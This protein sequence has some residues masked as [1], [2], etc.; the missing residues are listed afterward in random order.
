M[1]CSTGHKLYES[2]LLHA[3]TQWCTATAY[4]NDYHAARSVYITPLIAH[5]FS[6]GLHNSIVESSVGGKDMLLDMTSFGLAFKDTPAL[7]SFGQNIQLML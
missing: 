6:A 4:H 3:K 1:S 7:S 2:S 5:S